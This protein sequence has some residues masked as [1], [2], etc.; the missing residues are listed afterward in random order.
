MDKFLQELKNKVNNA[1]EPEMSSEHWGKFTKF[2]EINSLPSIKPITA[3]AKS[4]FSLVSA[5][6]ISLVFIFSDQ[7]IPHSNINIVNSNTKSDEIIY[8]NNSESD[9][10]IPQA[11]INM[12]DNMIIESNQSD[13]KKL[14]LGEKDFDKTK[15]LTLKKLNLIS[16]IM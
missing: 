15:N 9:N 6:A 2:R 11:N 4:I 1:K 13:Q 10:L 16:Q 14:T 3:I 8:S 5:V 7:I 12:D